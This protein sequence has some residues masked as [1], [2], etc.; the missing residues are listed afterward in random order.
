M[1]DP[2]YDAFENRILKMLEL[3]RLDFDL[4]IKDLC[5]NYMNNSTIGKLP[6]DILEIVFKNHT[7]GYKKH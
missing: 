4:E 6:K 7:E 2:T 5:F 1:T 3:N